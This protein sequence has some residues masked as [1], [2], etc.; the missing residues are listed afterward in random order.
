MAKN[1]STTYNCDLCGR[2]CNPIRHMRIVRS[3]DGRDVFSTYSIDLHLDIG[4]GPSNADVCKRC[5]VDYL[6]EAIS[7]LED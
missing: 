3:M 2:K 5:T 1:T 4:Y 6:K 7:K